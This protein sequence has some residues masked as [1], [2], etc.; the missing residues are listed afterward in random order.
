MTHSSNI[1]LFFFFPSSE[2][3]SHRPW[4][5][6]NLECMRLPICIFQMGKK[7][8]FKFEKKK[9]KSMKD[10]EQMYFFHKSAIHSGYC[11]QQ[12]D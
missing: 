1:I 10:Q 6:G 2:S 4:V 5:C 8:P 11:E 12:S 7:D 9:K 3:P